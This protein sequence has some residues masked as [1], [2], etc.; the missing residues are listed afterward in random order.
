MERKTAQDV[1]Q[2]LLCIFDQ[3]MHGAPWLIPE[4]S[5]DERVINA[6]ISS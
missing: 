6:A 2:E 5:H 1:D 3:Y 4:A